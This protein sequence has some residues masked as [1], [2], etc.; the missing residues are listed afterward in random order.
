MALADLQQQMRQAVVTG[1]DRALRASIIGGVEPLR[2]LAIHRRH[3]RTSLRAVITHRF[4]ATA[5]LIGGSRLEDAARQFVEQC[6]PT[7]PCMAEYGDAFP[8]FLR[9]WPGIASMDYVADFADLDWHLGRVSVCVDDA[10]ITRE[11]LASFDPGVLPDQ[12]V[13]LQGG[14]HYVA[15]SWPVDTLMS[16]YLRDAAPDAWTLTD[17]AVAVQVRGSR[18]V[19]HVRRLDRGTFTFR[20]AL[21]RGASLGDAAARSL[22]IDPV[23]DVGAA[24]RDAIDEQLVTSV[25]GTHGGTRC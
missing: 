5:W 3:Y 19:L 12:R 9:T 14:C 11:D 15:A 17:E 25:G 6:P 4:P 16:L 18:G 24:L 20:T 1:D 8:A 7:M 10:A 13:S 2:R 22:E 21:A 23:F